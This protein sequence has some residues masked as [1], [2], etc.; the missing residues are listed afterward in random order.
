M[1]RRRSRPAIWREVLFAAHW[2]NAR[3]LEGNAGD[4]LPE[5]L[6]ARAYAWINANVS[7]FRDLV[8]D[9]KTRWPQRGPWKLCT[10][11]TR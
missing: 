1:K 8:A 6:S 5:L 11:E 7:T 3:G 9:E 10:E 4:P 2:L